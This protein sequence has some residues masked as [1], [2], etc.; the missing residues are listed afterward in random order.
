MRSRLKQAEP[1][2]FLGPV[3]F[4]VWLCAT[5]F[6][7]NLIGQEPKI[8]GRPPGD[9]TPLV[10]RDPYIEIRLNDKNDN[11]ILHV[12]PT[13]R[14]GSGNRLSPPFNL[15]SRGVCVFRFLDD[16]DVE[17][18][19]AFASI[20]SIQSFE[21]LL[22]AEAEAALG[23]E[24]YFRAF[25]NYLYLYDRNRASPDLRR[26]LE[27][28]LYLD[29]KQLLDSGQY[30]QALSVLEELYDRNPR[31]R[32]GVEGGLPAAIENCY[33]KIL[34][35]NAERRELQNIRR[36]LAALESNYGDRLRRLID[37]WN[38]ELG[39]VAEQV[40]ADAQQA[41]QSDDG[42]TAHEKVRLMIY[43]AP[44][45]DE[46][47]QLFS[48]LVERFPIVFV[49]ASQA[50]ETFRRN[51]IEHWA[52]MRVGGLTHRE[53]LEF[54]EP[55]DDGGKY[56]FP[57]GSFRQVGDSG[58]EYQFR[59][60]QLPSDPPRLGVPPISAYEVSARLLKLGK[61]RGPQ[62]HLPWVRMKPS[63]RIDDART[64]SVRL[65]TPYVLPAALLQAPY[66]M[67]P[68][69]G[70]PVENGYY[71]TR[72]R[73]EQR[74]VYELNPAYP[75]VA[76]R[77][78]P[79]LVE[80]IYNSRSALTE[81]LE[82]GEVDVVDRVF[83]TDI[84]RLKANPAIQVQS[85]SVPTM[86]M[87]I[88]HERGNEF[89]QIRD[90]KAGL[91]YAVD[92]DQIVNQMLAG[93]LG[94]GGFEV[95][96]GPLPVGSD[97]FDQT[98]Y[99]YDSLIQPAP[100]NYYLGVAMV[101]FAEQL[102]AGKLLKRTERVFRDE[103]DKLTTADPKQALLAALN[104]TFKAEGGLEQEGLVDRLLPLFSEYLP[105]SDEAI[106]RQRISEFVEELPQLKSAQLVLAYPDDDLAEL[107]CQS[108]QQQWQVI[109]VDCQL[110][111][112]PRGVVVPADDEYDLLYAQIT[113]REPFMDIQQLL[114]DYGL[115]KDV[116]ASI[117]QELNQIGTA[118]RFREV[119]SSLRA[120]HNHCNAELAVIP[121][122]Q[123]FEHYAYRKNLK[124]VGSRLSHLYQNVE[125]WQLDPPDAD[126]LRRT[127]LDRN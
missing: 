107:A 43:A 120:I 74:S 68:E 29:G 76:G 71:V 1:G 67:Q 117:R 33:D 12:E 26:A 23:A 2:A 80:K 75:P 25:K 94:L 22:L 6:A 46:A 4:A 121:L 55:G 8:L 93:G 42:F 98:A 52:D 104:D 58:M 126:Q 101:S 72:E 99:G 100:H 84:P 39:R 73:N 15:P 79:L 64:V 105:E 63:V 45:I 31:A 127:L 16:A 61:F 48:E 85:Y 14:D 37:K 5:V 36:I 110:R 32:I 89:M 9:S 111:R 112:L 35:D 118:D 7:T 53:M 86:H 3:L 50:P 124:N 18:E 115:A 59:I 91:L 47:P 34:E 65:S 97:E 109:G 106:L 17:Y 83:P 20:E 24:D 27:Q 60:D 70:L 51:R 82:R 108:L 103:F 77:Q 81:A 92:R 87:L 28:Y 113:M 10:E 57:S 40:Y 38:G 13:L 119:S 123:T 49:G 116:S 125:L 11:A 78:H 96:S 88:P 66:G 114:G 21:Q 122:W 62:M 54:V 44:E 95:V 69:A 19:V 56:V 30:V 41:V 90:F 102:Q